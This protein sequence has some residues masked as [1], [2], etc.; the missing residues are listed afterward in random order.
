MPTK[1]GA[2]GRPQNYDPHTGRFAKQDPMKILLA[3]ISKEEKK[4]R[5]EKARREDLYNRAR[6]S[7]DEYVFET[8]CAIEKALPGAV[9]SVNEY[10]YDPF[11]KNIREFDI[12]TKK[13]IIEVKGKQAKNCLTQGLEQKRYARRV[14][15]Q[16]ILYAPHI[17]YNRFREYSEKGLLIARSEAELI[18]KIKEYEK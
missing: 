11:I 3:P 14:G 9:Q 10:K 12:I 5:A 13:C 2:G 4:R 15:K 16:H 7:K 17:V 18:I 6:N 1:K 8:Y